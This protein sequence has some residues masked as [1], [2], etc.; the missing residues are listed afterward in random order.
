MWSHWLCIVTPGKT[1]TAS[2]R[3]TL[4]CS[5]SCFNT[6]NTKDLRLVLGEIRDW[7]QQLIRYLPVQ[8]RDR[9][10]PKETLQLGSTALKERTLTVH[11]QVIRLRCFRNY[12]QALSVLLVTWLYYRLIPG[13]PGLHSG[14]RSHNYSLTYV[15]NIYFFGSLGAVT[16]HT[17][18]SLGRLQPRHNQACTYA[19]E[20]SS[21]GFS[22]CD[23]KGKGKVNKWGNRPEMIFL[24][25]LI[26]C[27]G[28]QEVPCFFILCHFT[29]I[30][31]YFT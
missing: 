12:H 25:K 19:S 7:V 14:C 24:L 31:Q 18:F 3:L 5:N 6:W 9:A 28:S 21:S 16:F 27:N 2:F 23:W 15:R 10:P 17:S 30:F 22:Q 1:S 11:E 29:R 20:S 13:R 8:S 26:I 4:I